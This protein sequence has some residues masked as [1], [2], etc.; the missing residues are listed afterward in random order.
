MTIIAF[1]LWLSKALKRA[2]AIKTS[3][4]FESLVCDMDW[5]HLT[6]CGIYS[7]SKCS[8]QVI[9]IPVKA[10]WSYIRSLECT[11]LGAFT[12]F[13]VRALCYIYRV[14]TCFKFLN[15][16]YFI[17]PEHGSDDNKIWQN[18]VT[19]PCRI[20][21]LVVEQTEQAKKQLCSLTLKQREINIYYR[22][23]YTTV[24]LP[25]IQE[26]SWSTCNLRNSSKYFCAYFIPGELTDLRKIHKCSCALLLSLCVHK[27]GTSKDCK[28]VSFF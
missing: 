24:C 13:Q 28:V 5:K 25:I 6:A 14:S 22:T 16:S 1:P 23:D 8:S 10:Q 3:T 7:N 4:P 12:L 18:N 9:K 11:Q 20:I 27:T 15:W 17:S 2:Q 19:S 26:S 21:H